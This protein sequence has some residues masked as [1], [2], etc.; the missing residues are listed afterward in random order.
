MNILKRGLF[1]VT[2]VLSLYP[3]K[4]F[5]HGSAEEYAS[6]SV[7]NGHIPLY[8]AIV[9]AVLL[10]IFIIM[11]LVIKSKTSKL[12]IRKK[13]ERGQ[14]S[15]LDRLLKGVRLGTVLLLVV[16]V[17][18][19][20]FALASKGSSVTFTHVHGLDFTA[21]GEKIVVPSHDGLRVF[22]KGSWHVGKGQQNDYM[23]FAMTD[24]GFYSSGHPGEGSDLKNPV[25]IIKSTDGGKTVTSLGFS[26]ASDFHVMDVGFETH[27]IY[28]FNMGP[29]SKMNQNGLYYSTDDA[30]TWAQSKLTGFDSQP[31]SIAVHPQKENTVAIGAKDGIYV[32]H[33]NG[34][35]VKNIFL[36]KQVTAIVYASNG[37]IWAG[38]FHSVAGLYKLDP[39]T[40]DAMKIDVPVKQG[41][42]IA[43]ISQNPK[44]NQEI[45]IATYKKD[46]YLSKDGG[47]SWSIIVDEGKGIN[48]PAD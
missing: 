37:D 14:K 26:G 13:E 25:G 35:T 24:D 48:L 22:E 32:S 20:G 1:F 3:L 2:L 8:I 34:N 43:Y 36:G 19:S 16:T 47:K 33:D 9:A 4:A 39:Q 11:W 46:S 23:G 12:D 44:K 10:I 42:A 41:D 17:V 5:A 45:V 28:T 29:N 21:D 40:N 7:N 18:A 15:K 38:T 6:K 30:K 31:S 27:A